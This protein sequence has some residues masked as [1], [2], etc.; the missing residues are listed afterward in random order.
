MC[1]TDPAHEIEYTRIRF[2]RDVY[3]VDR[4]EIL[5]KL[6]ALEPDDDTQLNHGIQRLLFH[7]LVRNG[8]LEQIKSAVDKAAAHRA[9]ERNHGIV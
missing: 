8:H 6:G 4:R 7:Y 1:T 5:T 2:F 3:D 9:A